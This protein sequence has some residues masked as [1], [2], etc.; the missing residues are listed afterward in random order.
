MQVL[1]PSVAWT[2]SFPYLSGF[3]IF[4][5]G[6]KTIDS[7]HLKTL[8]IYDTFTR[9]WRSGPSLPSPWSGIENPIV[10][11]V[12][13]LLFVIGG[14]IQFENALTMKGLL[15]LSV[16]LFPTSLLIIPL[17]TLGKTWHQ[18]QPPEQAR[19]D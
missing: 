2:F 7:A 16:V 17:P 11:A 12:N 15:G 3:Q 19:Q 13:K 14:M 6:G 18:C 9:T 10:L 5:V 8:T 1:I 4:L